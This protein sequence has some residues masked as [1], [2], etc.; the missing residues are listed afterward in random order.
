MPLSNVVQEGGHHGRW[1]VDTSRS[2]VASGFQ[3]VPLVHWGLFEERP[4]ENRAEN[5]AHIFRL[6]VAEGSC[7]E[8]G[9]E[10][11]RQMAQSGVGVKF[12]SSTCS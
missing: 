5:R 4:P 2:D 9:E 6:L 7:S 1:I 3:P 11:S 12:S 10:A 8:N